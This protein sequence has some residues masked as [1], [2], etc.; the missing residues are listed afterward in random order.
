MVNIPA[1]QTARAIIDGIDR[2]K[3]LKDN[4]ASLKKAFEYNSFGSSEALEQL[5]PF[6]VQ[7]GNNASVPANIKKDLYDFTT[8][9][10]EEKIKQTP[11][12]ARYQLFAGSYFNSRNQ[13]DLALPYVQKAIELSPRKPAMY[14]ELA[15]SYL[16]K[17]DVEGAFKQFEVGY[18]LEPRYREGQILYALGAI[19]AGKDDIATKMFNTLGTDTVISDNR[20]LNAFAAR[21]DYN[22]V[23]QIL[24]ARIQKNPKNAEAKFNL[25]SV[26]ATVGQKQM[27]ITL[28]KELIAD[29]PDWKNQGEAYIK[30]L[31]K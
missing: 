21:K 30:E 4:I 5:V 28:I 24:T 8:E 29:Y 27:A 6:S 9:K 16:A 13:P 31:S 15:N 14:F 19:Y 10:V 23:I 2:R 26:Y 7:V 17:G 22:V 12:D 3:D 25:A 18:N 20:I 1:M 11:N